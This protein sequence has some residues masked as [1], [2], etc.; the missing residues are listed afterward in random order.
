MG[1]I[2]SNI[3]H[4]VNGLVSGIRLPV[5]STREKLSDGSLTSSFLSERL[6]QIEETADMTIE[7]TQSIHK[8]FEPLVR[9]P[10]GVNACLI[11]ALKKC[12][13]LSSAI[14][15]NVD[16]DKTL[17]PVTA[18]QQLD[19]VFQNLLNNAIEAMQG[20]G[21]LQITSRQVGQAVEIAVTDSGPGLGGN[22]TAANIFDLG[23]STKKDRL[24]YGLWWCKIYLNRIGGSIRLDTDVASGCRFVVKL[25][26]KY[27]P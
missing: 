14:E 20:K 5:Q 3:L 4:K 12:K 15:L 13:Y 1:D 19:E 6:A 21:K 11:V 23:K 17:P 25:P 7:I 2:A 18:T 16:L 26:L 24:G 9:E 27:E 8:P 10:I 22:L